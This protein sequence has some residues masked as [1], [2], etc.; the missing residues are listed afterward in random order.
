MRMNLPSRTRQFPSPG[1]VLA[2]ALLCLSVL[3]FGTSSAQENPPETIHIGGRDWSLFSSGVRSYAFFDV[4]Q[5]A[6]Y[7]D[8]RQG[9]DLD[10]IQALSHPVGIRIEVLTSEMPEEVPDPWK[11][12]IRPE[13]S[14]KLYNRF[15][16]K[17][18][19]LNQGDVL[20]FS[21]LP[22][23]ATVFYLNAEKKFSDPG[24]GLFEALLEQWIGAKPVSEDLKAA[25]LK[26]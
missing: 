1:N 17:F 22:D 24:P 11:E 5:C 9:G 25:L 12:A 8:S 3:S 20:F 2:F 15:K 13:L 6:L 10:S 16:K 21:Y 19:K 4:Y 26:N 23:Q 14:D 18:F 7:M